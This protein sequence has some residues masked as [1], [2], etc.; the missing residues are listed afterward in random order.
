MVFC[1]LIMRFSMSRLRQIYGKF[2]QVTNIEAIIKFILGVEYIPT[3]INTDNKIDQLFSNPEFSD[4]R[5]LMY[6]TMIWLLYTALQFIINY[7][8]FLQKYHK[9]VNIQIYRL[10]AL[11][12]VTFINYAIIFNLTKLIFP[13]ADFLKQIVFVLFQVILLDYFFKIV[14]IKWILMII[15]RW[16]LRNKIIDYNMSQEEADK[17]YINPE[18]DFI[19]SLYNIAQQ[20]Y[21]I[22]SFNLICPI[23]S[24]FG[25][26]ILMITFMIDKFLI[27]KRASIS[28][29]GIKMGL[30]FYRLWNFDI[31][32]QII[33]MLIFNLEYNPDEYVTG[34]ILIAG[35]CYY[36]FIFESTGGKRK[37]K[38]MQKFDTNFSY[39]TIKKNFK[40]TFW[41]QYQFN[42][43][44]RKYF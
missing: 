18:F 35:I 31:A 44:N 30:H 33:A 24:F 29:S 28:F 26:I 23:L 5:T 43:N 16:R 20:L 7:L 14:N 36:I 9:Y 39:D 27:L 8:G 42:I 11:L 41:T 34:I 37:K 12:A 4:F 40:S 21:L 17:L 13:P 25:I 19:V 10:K 15:K 3:D 38:K 22:L 2:N 1:Y 6:A 32:I